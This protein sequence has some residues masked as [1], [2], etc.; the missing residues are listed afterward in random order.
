MARRTGLMHDEFVRESIA[1]DPELAEVY[2]EAWS[3]TELGYAIAEFREQRGMTRRAL[4]EASGI[5]QPM[6]T[7]IERGAQSPTVPTLQKLLRALDAT[8]EVGGDHITVR[9]T[10]AIAEL[11]ISAGADRDVD[12][13]AQG[14]ETNDGWSSAASPHPS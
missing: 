11:S 2:A 14:P 12:G 6:I 10:G 3:E 8:L 9:P 13:P 1:R 7:R 5:A 4:A